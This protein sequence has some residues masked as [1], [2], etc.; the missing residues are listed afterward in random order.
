MKQSEEIS[1]RNCR[2]FR[3]DP[4]FLESAF[5]GLSALGSAWGSTRSDDGLCL[6]HHRHLSAE[7]YCPDFTP[8]N[9]ATSA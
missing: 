2:H 7:S 9:A 6:Q 5:A 8:G 4:A 3:N 1:C